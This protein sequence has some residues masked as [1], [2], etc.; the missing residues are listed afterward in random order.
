MND[1]VLGYSLAVAGTAGALWLG[2]QKQKEREQKGQLI[3]AATE[4]P[5]HSLAAFCLLV[6]GGMALASAKPGVAEGL[7]KGSGL[8][9]LGVAGSVGYVYFKNREAKA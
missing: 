3:M 1:K 5:A 2:H 6:A 9:M 7:V 8:A 4:M